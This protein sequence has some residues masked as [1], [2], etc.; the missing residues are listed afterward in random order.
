MIKA[1]IL[2]VDQLIEKAGD[3]RLH[4]QPVWVRELVQQMA[5]QLRSMNAHAMTL[6]E[7]AE[8]AANEATALLGQGPD[9]SDTYMDLPRS[10]TRYSDDGEGQRP[11]GKG[12]NIEFRGPGDESGE[13]INAKWAKDHLVIHGMNR[14]AVI[15]QDNT[16]VHIETR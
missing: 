2:S 5:G 6:V 9:D 15:P 13:G 12:T 1:M 3:P 11:L 14:L 16:T 10:V 7:N 8:Q 4:R